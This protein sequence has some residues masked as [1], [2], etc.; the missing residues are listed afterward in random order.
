MAA[1]YPPPE[2]RRA[3]GRASQWRV[4]LATVLVLV[5]LGAAPAPG[6]RA[7]HPPPIGALLAGAGPGGEERPLAQLEGQPW[8]LVEYQGT[9]G[10]LQ[11]VLAGTEITATFREGRLGGSAGC[12]S[13]GSIYSATGDALTLGEAVRTLR[14]CATPPGVMEQEAA[15][16][17]VLP[18]TTRLEIAPDALILRDASGG[19]LL[20]FAPQ[21]QTS[22]EG[23]AWTAQAYNNGRGGVVS[24]LAGTEITARFEGDR[25]VGSAGCNT[26]TAAYALN[27]NA[28]E[29]GPAATTRMACPVPPGRMEQ[30][31]AYLAALQTAREYRIEG[32][33]LILETA[34]GA[35]VASFV[36]ANGAGTPD[37]SPLAADG[38]HAKIGFDLAAIDASGLTGPPAGQVAVAYEFCIP[39]TA[40]H[41]AEVERLDPTVQVMPGSP[42]R[43]GCRPGAEV[44][45]IGS[46]HQPDWRTVLQALA[47]LDY[48]ARI[49]RHVAE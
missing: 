39:A 36:P 5:L 9:D 40:A 33:R 7:A 3:S 21:P 17:A 49:D 32:N 43:I 41:L 2:C 22:L 12:N 26:Y 8:T 46:T 29:I 4:R 20:R 10:A 6:G 27:G 25:V 45:C 44:L 38:G 34:D 18:R 35:R 30:E 11:P 48:V 13:Y 19:I 47:G 42:G 37:A 31:A 16:L 28:I 23:T 24:L 1:I 15:Y 14:L